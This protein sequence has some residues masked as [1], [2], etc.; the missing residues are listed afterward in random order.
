M[1]KLHYWL[2]AR[3][4]DCRFSACGSQAADLPPKHLW[5]ILTQLGCQGFH[6]AVRRSPAAMLNRALARIG[7]A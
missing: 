7:F 3:Y 6:Q 4:W 1:R 2:S 5:I